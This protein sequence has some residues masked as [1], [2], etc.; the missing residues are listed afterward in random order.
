MQSRIALRMLA[1]L[2]A[3]LLLAVAPT[4]MAAAQE[5]PEPVVV[6]EEAPV[7]E[8]EGIAPAPV[9]EDET[10]EP[11][12]LDR[13]DET[14]ALPEEPQPA[15]VTDDQ[16]VIAPAPGSDVTIGLEESDGF[17]WE[18]VVV[19]ALVVGSVGLGVV[20]GWWIASHRRH[21]PIAH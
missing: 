12:P 20:G 6:T 2:A 5:Q 3:A 8:G 4:A 13:D 1:V 7:E 21:E 17:A 19:A 18:W 10:V 9:A 15:P 11:Q 14:P 16:S